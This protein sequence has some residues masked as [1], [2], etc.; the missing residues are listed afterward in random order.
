MNI[1]I[2]EDQTTLDL[3]PIV[4]TR[5]SFDLRC[6]AFTFLERV[7]SLLPDARFSLIVREELAGLTQNRFPDLTVNPS[8]VQSGFWLKGAVLWD[9]KTLDI[10]MEKGTILTSHGEIVAAS[11]TAEQG[12]RW[13]SEGGPLSGAPS[14]TLRK[15]KTDVQVIRYLWDC[16]N[17]NGKALI[18]DGESFS[19]GS[20]LNGLLEKVQLVNPD[21]VFIGKDCS[22]KPG[23]VFDAEDGPIIIGNDATILSHTY[24]Q[25][26]LFIGNGCLVKAGTCIY[27]GASIGPGCKLGGEISESIFQGWSNKQHDGFIGHAYIGEWVNLGADTNNSDLKNNY[28]D[29]Q[30]KVNGRT[31]DTG[32]P[33]VGLF[34][35]DHGKSGINTMFN[36]GTTIGPGANVVG[37][38]YPPVNILPLSW[39]INGKIRPYQFD[40]FCATAQKVK[41]R[42]G[43]KFT[44]EEKQ[45]F[46]SLS[47]KR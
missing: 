13:L 14:E 29:V 31:V 47:D 30:V 41:E 17:L 27:G 16:V 25:G 10:S 9:E 40:K 24:L 39:S 20:G 4:L 43:K 26:P 46:R 2:Y 37:Y 42:R 21:G 28:A 15:E 23:V 34:M 32:S 33:Y 7:Q 36:T 18:S 44:P 6:G 1:Y 5:P 45:L 35:G 3:E 19:L 8:E 22:I 11:L 12:N 38:G